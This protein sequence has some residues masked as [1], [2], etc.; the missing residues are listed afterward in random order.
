MHLGKFLALRSGAIAE[1]QKELAEFVQVTP[2]S[3][4]AELAI[5][6]FADMQTYVTWGPGGVTLKESVNLPQG[7]SKAVLEVS[8]TITK[9]GI[10]IRFKLADKKG[11]LDSLA[12]RFG[13]F[14]ERKVVDLNVQWEFVIGEGYVDGTETKVI[15][16]EV[17]DEV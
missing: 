2:E 1:R 7:A 10:T 12:K 3:I 5:L 6:S 11:A 16:G 4:T 14:V 15:E 9:E 17:I 8:E 13:M